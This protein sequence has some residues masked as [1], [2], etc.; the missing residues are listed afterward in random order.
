MEN[1]QLT[2]TIEEINKILSALGQQPYIQVFELI[3]KIQL[4]VTEQLKKTKP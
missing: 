1:A 4:Q 2:L 3:T